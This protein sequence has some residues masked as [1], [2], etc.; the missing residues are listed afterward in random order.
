MM[1]L[2][3]KAHYAALAMLA[4]AKRWETRE[5]VTAKAI[6]QEQGIPNQFLLQILQQLRS[7][8][9]ITSMR[10]ANGGFLLNRAP[11]QINLSQVVDS[12]CPCTPQE[13]NA[14]AIKVGLEAESVIQAVWGEVADS[15]RSILEQASLSNLLAR[16]SETQPMFYI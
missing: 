11:S 3:V 8:G 12:V 9:L 13:L 5:L 4:L 6:A 14:S 15:Q 10:G 16:M 1:Q 7:S 2:P